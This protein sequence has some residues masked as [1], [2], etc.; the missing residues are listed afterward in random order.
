MPQGTLLQEQRQQAIA[1]K[2]ELS[3]IVTMWE[4]GLSETVLTAIQQLLNT[5]VQNSG[6]SGEDINSKEIQF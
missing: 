3:P 2:N 5:N 1:M 6:E 4:N